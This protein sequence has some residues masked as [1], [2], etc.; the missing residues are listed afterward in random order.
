[1]YLLVWDID[2]TLIRTQGAG[3][4]AM[5]KA[6]FELYG[7]KDGFKYISMA[8]RLDPLILKEALMLHGIEK[9]DNKIFFEL[10]CKYLQEEI[11]KTSFSW[12]MPGTIELLETLYKKG[13]FYNALGTGNIEEGARIKLSVHDM[14]KFFPVGGFAETETERWQIIQ[15]AV[16]KSKK[17]FNINFENSNIYVIGDTPYDIECAKILNLKSIG[18]A[19]GG[20]SEEHLLKCNANYVFKDFTNIKAFLSIFNH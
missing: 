2:G 7:I 20:Y 17:Y 4:R 6:F 10:Y 18:V 9:E 13:C 1:M 19:T 15:K 8:G 3:K 14:N 5:E 16:V 12:A 11:K